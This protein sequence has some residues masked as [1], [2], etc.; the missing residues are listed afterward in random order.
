MFYS[1][2]HLRFGNKIVTHFLGPMCRIPFEYHRSN[3]YLFCKLSQETMLLFK[4]III[5]HLEQFLGKKICDKVKM[6]TAMEDAYCR[7]ENYFYW[8]MFVQQGIQY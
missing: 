8:G 5:G 1:K 3:L 6:I 7:V 2:Y 4:Q